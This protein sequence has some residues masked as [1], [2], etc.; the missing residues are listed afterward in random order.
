MK[1]DSQPVASVGDRAEEVQEDRV[2]DGDEI[3]R[4]E[5]PKTT[6]VAIWLGER[7]EALKPKK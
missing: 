6:P 3:M 1:I 5:A 7:G 4:A 2:G